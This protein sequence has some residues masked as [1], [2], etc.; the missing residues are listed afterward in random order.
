MSLLAGYTHTSQK[1]NA[2]IIA[3]SSP[4]RPQLLFLQ[5][6]VTPDKKVQ[7]GARALGRASAASLSLLGAQNCPLQATVLETPFKRLWQPVSVLIIVQ[8][9]R[10]LLCSPD[11][12]Q[13][14]HKTPS[15]ADVDATCFSSMCAPHRHK[16]TLLCFCTPPPRGEQSG[17]LTLVRPS[18]QAPP[19]EGAVMLHPRGKW[20]ACTRC[21]HKP[22][23]RH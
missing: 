6:N 1:H 9:A 18:E 13:A 10:P 23:H 16:N 20:A 21:L 8:G 3:G 22:A 11:Y 15:T 5:G 4:R 12:K 14:Y 7:A 2:L 19:P 17:S